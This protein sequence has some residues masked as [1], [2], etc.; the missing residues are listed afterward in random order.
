MAQ[1]HISPKVKLQR[2]ARRLG[3]FGVSKTSMLLTVTLVLI[4]MVSSVALVGTLLVGKKN[5][6][7][8]DKNEEVLRLAE[9]KQEKIESSASDTSSKEEVISIHIAGSVASPGLYSLRGE[10]LRIADALDAAGGAL[11]DANIDSLNLA[12]PIVDGQ[13]VYVP[14][15]GEEAVKQTEAGSAES[16]QSTGS[17]NSERVNINT[18]TIDALKSLPGIG[19]LTAKRIIEDRNKNGKFS[20]VEDLMRVSG[21]GSKK[22]EK[23]KAYIYV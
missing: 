5:Q 15:L 16:D 3:L 19:E 21:I 23:L 20:T 12:E 1:E 9:D 8:L 14:K 7:I 17:Q 22:F 18:A 4:A 6:A 11:D 10:G 2:L 13:K